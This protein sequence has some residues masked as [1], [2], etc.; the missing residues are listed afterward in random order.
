MRLTPLLLLVPLLAA[1][2]CSSKSTVVPPMPDAG[3]SV[4]LAAG[5][6][7]PKFRGDAAQ[8]GR[9]TVKPSQTGGTYWDFPTGKG[10]FSSP[11]VGAD[12]TVY[13]GSADQ[14]FYAINKDGSQRW[15]VTTGEIIDSSGLLDDMGRVYFGSGD[16]LLRACDAA[17][18]AVA[19]TFQADSPTENSAYLNWFEGNVAIGPDG[20]LYAPN[21]NYFIYAVDRSGKLV[22]KFKTPDQTWSLPA[23]DVTTGDLYVGNN[24]LLSFLGNNTFAIGKDGENLWD[25][26]TPGTIAASPTLTAGGAVIMG[27]FDGFVHAYKAA[28]GTPLWSTATRD[29]VY[30]SPALLSDGTIVQPSA[31]GTLYALDPAT[32]NVRWTFDTP[33]PIRSS[34]AVDGDDNVYFGGGD[35]T[36]YVVNKDGSFRWSMLL[37]DQPRQNLNASPALAADAI[38]LGGESGEVFSVPY[39][40]CL[41]PTAQP[42]PR[43]NTKP[44]SLGPETGATLIFTKP[45]GG[46]AF[47]PPAQVNGNQP[48]AFSL[49]VRSAGRTELAILDSASLTVTVTPSVPVTVDLAGDGKFVTITPTSGFTPDASGNVTVDLQGSYLVNLDRT[50][51]KL[52]GGTVGGMVEQSF[53]FALTPAA[54]YPL[55]A[56]I[57]MQPGDPAGV[58]ELSRISLP[59]PTILPSYNQ[60]GFDSLHYLIG[61]VEGT[62]DRALAWMVGGKV[63]EGQTDAVVD[64]ATQTLL[65]LVVTY[66]GGALTLA[67]T[68][69]LTVNVQNVNIPLSTFRVSTFL[70]A[71]GTAAAGAYLSGSTVCGKIPTYGP[72]LQQLGFCNPQTDVLS[73]LGGA[74]F[75]PY[76]SGT[77]TAPT[78]V[79]TVA[80]SADA[81]N[82]TAT[83]TGATMNV[84]D[85]VASVF[86]IDPTTG[87]PITLSYGPETTRTPASGPLQT[88]SVPIAGLTLPSMLRVYLMIDTYPAAVGMVTV[89]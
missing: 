59:Y 70:A 75:A 20:T 10:V 11:I 44:P 4:P 17:T 26:S 51:L 38:I 66:Q 62:S 5:S 68:A 25:T 48:L 83:L 71:D 73:V 9:S 1:P 86:L 45:F 88:V 57:P 19:W 31:D 35:G 65:P 27:G 8:D 39:D 82:V 13:V 40:Y 55:A 69:G 54:S 34:P 77:S 81:N 49:L 89:P 32:G 58:F 36:L 6:P 50:G 76:G 23:V 47:T 2:A 41:R 46:L 29:H 79:G 3:P 15:K 85:H 43:C 33:E 14:N 18:G 52:S 74:N 60:I 84:Q 42:D 16:G 30:A 61:L 67:N 64:P 37:I 56:P 87:D 24:E 78:G 7:W 53:T 63:I 28:D 21:D 22:W 80:F 12:G 72:F